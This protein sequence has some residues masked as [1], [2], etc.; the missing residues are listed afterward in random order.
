MSEM[1]D[2]SGFDWENM[3]YS[4][5]APE[6]GTPS[7]E[8]QEADTAPTERLRDERGRYVSAPQ[9]EEPVAETPEQEGPQ[10]PEE[11][12]GILNKYGGDPYRALSGM[13]ELQAL[14]GRQSQ[15][16]GELR[17]TVNQ[18]QQYIA[19]RE[20][21]QTA[22]TDYSS[23][24]DDTGA[25]VEAMYQNRDPRWQMALNHWRQ[26]DPV[27]ANM[28]ATLK[29]QEILIQQNQQ[30]ARQ[31]TEQT[32]EGLF[33][34]GF[35]QLIANNPDLESRIPEI[36]QWIESRPHIQAVFDGPDVRAR[37]AVIEDALIASRARSTETVKAATKEM[38]T[39]QAQAN[40]QALADAYVASGD[41][42]IRETETPSL[43]DQIIEEWEG[44]PSGLHWGE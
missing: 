13:A 42:A 16:V 29:Q 22:Q 10:I 30:F 33:Q 3:S 36:G 24:A 44:I 35:A 6:E 37:L 25:V 26:E 23:Y 20:Q 17:Q 1:T 8:A 40:E 43:E 34:Q 21:A 41:T 19:S 14:Q 32:N 7:E 5:E 39:A 27:L 2:P 15:E 28:W 18:L 38:A 11:I 31:T 4:D 12:Q 9:E